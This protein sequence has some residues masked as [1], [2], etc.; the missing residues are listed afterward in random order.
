MLTIPNGVH[1]LD[2]FKNIVTLVS[3]L[4][5]SSLTHKLPVPTQSSCFSLRI[6]KLV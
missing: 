5:N 2:S 1:C 6:E 4:K 3:C